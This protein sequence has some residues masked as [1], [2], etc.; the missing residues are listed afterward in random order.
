MAPQAP[1]LTH[2]RPRVIRNVA[3]AATLALLYNAAQNWIE[4]RGR[5]ALICGLGGLATAGCWTLV[6][7]SDPSSASLRSL[8]VAGHG[9]LAVAWLVVVSAALMGP[10]FYHAGAVYVLTFGSA[11]IVMLGLGAGIAW[12]V[13]GWAGLA[14]LAWVERTGSVVSTTPLRD[15]IWQ[16]LVDY[17][18][19]YALLLSFSWFFVREVRRSALL[20]AE[21][22]LALAEEN[23]QRRRAELEARA[24][25]SAR[26]HFLATVSHEIRTPMN[27]ILGMAGEIGADPLP[28]AQR[29]RLELLERSA[30]SLLGLLSDLLDYSRLESGKVEL[31]RRPFSLVGLAEEIVRLNRPLITGPVELALRVEDLPS[32]T[33]LGDELRCRQILQ[34]LV[35]NAIKFTKR[36]R[37]EVRLGGADPDLTCIEVIDT[38]AGIPEEQ[39][40]HISEPFVQA[41]ASIARRFGGTGL[42]L[43]IVKRLA[44]AM[45]GELLIRSEVGVGSTFRLNLALP[46]AEL[47]R[48]PEVQAEALELGS[49]LSV[50]VCEDNVVNQRVILG[51]LRRLDVRCEI[52][53][54]GRAAVAQALEKPYAALLLDYQLPDID[55]PEVARA[56]RSAE[57]EAQHL[58]IIGLSANALADDRQTA[59]AAGM[60]DYLTKPVS[61][62]ALRRTLARW[63]KAA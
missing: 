54:N 34:N 58:P 32:P 20:L 14:F 62:E 10:G 50:L 24:A 31:E 9:L 4:G 37:I 63:A 53:D 11:A 18:I 1:A 60:D 39:L 61:I 56:I 36:G 23:K 52:V 59:L 42:G 19:T 17:T 13:V 44:E 2:L 45:G 7:R 35:S 30:K 16:D 48:A 47:E 22:N 26:A 41:D 27:S 3:T 12:T 33:V 5:E 51:Q 29:E 6:R 49:G 28:E 38:G 21:Q 43:A 15:W 55:G 40:R 46:A 25:T 8:R 57:A